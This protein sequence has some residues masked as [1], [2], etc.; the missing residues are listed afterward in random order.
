MSATAE[1]L[2]HELHDAARARGIDGYRRMSKRQL[3]E[4]LGHEPAADAAADE[5]AGPTVVESSRRGPLGL[6]TLRGASNAL[7]LETLESLADEAERLAAD[8]SVWLVAVTGAGKIFSAGA[9]LESMRGLPGAEVAGRG[10]AALRRFTELS[11]PTVAILNGHAVGGGVDLALACDWRIA[12]Q[13]ARLRF[14]HNQLG[15]TPPW[16][17]AERLPQLVGRSVALRLFALHEL[18]SAAEARGLG[19]V[20]EVAPEPRLLGRAESMAARM[21][22]GDRRAVIETTRLVRTQP[23][24]EEHERTFAQLW[25]ERSSTLQS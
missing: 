9:D 3:L 4:L 18:L 11:L 2:L 1:P 19:L 10:G 8:E 24:A 21:S 5:P 12:G 7:A 13:G 14:I 17:A 15:Y 20:D 22:R 23:A 25:D 16:G 6:L